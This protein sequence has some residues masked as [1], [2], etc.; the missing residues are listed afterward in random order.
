MDLADIYRRLRARW[1]VFKPVIPEVILIGTVLVMGTGFAVNAWNQKEIADAKSETA[2]W[3][4]NA[5]S[6][7]KTP[8]A[9]AQ[10]LD[11]LKG[12]VDTDASL[13]KSYQT[14]KAKT[15]EQMRVLASKVDEGQKKISEL[16]L[17]NEALRPDYGFL[18]KPSTDEA[19]NPTQRQLQQFY[20]EG[21]GILKGLTKETLSQSDLQ[22]TFSEEM[23]WRS[24]V[25]TWI[26]ANMCRSAQQY[27][28][29]LAIQRLEYGHR[30]EQDQ[31]ANDVSSFLVRLA[32]L[33]GQVSWGC[34][35]G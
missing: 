12:Q 8:A 18:L 9:N 2:I 24:R 26:S 5:A 35:A 30:G 16:E 32:V 31:I 21:F 22:E 19:G 25:D 3:Q 11:T 27:F 33:K 23:S 13:I 29:S 14:E 34:F 20:A 10:E 15:D 17:A 4:A 28:S 7:S 6:P 1:H